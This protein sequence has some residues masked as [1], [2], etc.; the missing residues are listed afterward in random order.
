M[1]INLDQMILKILQCNSSYYSLI[2]GI[3]AYKNKEMQNSWECFSKHAELGNLI[4]IY[5]K[6]VYVLDIKKNKK[7]ANQL[8]QKAAD[9]GHAKAQVRYAISLSDD[10]VILII[11][12]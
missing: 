11:R 9:R 12:K 2:E 7:L 3:V 10:D 5:W 8:F 6:G 1:A 4:A